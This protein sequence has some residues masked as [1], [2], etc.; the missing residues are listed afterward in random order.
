MAIV[1]RLYIHF[2]FCRHLCNYCDFYK[3]VRVDSSETLGF[4]KYLENSVEPHNQLLNENGLT[5]TDMASVF[6]GGGTPSLWGKEG[7]EYLDD[8]FQKLNVKLRKDC[9]FTVEVNPGSWKEEDLMAWRKLG[10][11]RFSLGIQSFNQT[12]IKHLDRVHSLDDVV[13]TLKF[14]NERELNFS[15]DFMLGLPFS[16][17][18]NRDVLE[19]LKEVLKYNPNHFSLYILTTKENYVHHN[20]L[21]TE[22]WIEKEYMDVSNFLKKHGYLHYEVS[23]FAKPGF[24]ST[25]NLAYWESDSVAAFGPSATGFLSS[26]RTR[27]KWRPARAEFEIEKLTEKEFKLEQLYMK[28]R[29]NRGLNFDDF[30]SE[31]ERP[32]IKNLTAEWQKTGLLESVGDGLYRLTSKGYLSMD[33][34]LNQIF[35]RTKSL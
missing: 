12:F 10:A 17:R 1:D 18:D 34:L 15:V 13:D 25:H 31:A 20:H 9:E 7:A 32:I 11:N 27:Y 8:F 29:T 21:P 22:E 19:E 3:K 35:A 28:F 24:E 4:H 6:I 16:E 33:G 14:F 5:M 2:P 30:F 26:S 23:N